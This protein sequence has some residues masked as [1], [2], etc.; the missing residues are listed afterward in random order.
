M[1]KIT[2]FYTSI[3]GVK[4]AIPI[5]A[6]SPLGNFQHLPN[7]IFVEILRNLS[8]K[9]LGILSMTS[10]E[11]REFI[12]STFIFSKNGFKKLNNYQYCNLNTLSDNFTCINSSKLINEIPPSIGYFVKRCTLVLPTEI[13]I[14]HLMQIFLQTLGTPTF[15]M[16]Q[17]Y[18]YRTAREVYQFYGTI[19]N[20]FVSGWREFE[21]YKVYDYLYEICEID[22]KIEIFHSITST[23]TLN[24]NLIELYIRLFFRMIFNLLP[25]SGITEGEKLKWSLTKFTTGTRKQ[26]AK[27][28]ILIFGPIMEIQNGYQGDPKFSHHIAWVEL[29]DQCF[30]NNSLETFGFIIRTLYHSSNHLNI[31]RQY[32]FELFKEII[33]IDFQWLNK[34]VAALLVYSGSS[35]SNAYLRYKFQ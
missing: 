19:I 20:C 13:R 25:E 28:F 7:E 26:T 21:A 31:D 10:S 3:R 2:K 17:K 16:F 11:I 1:T 32:V 34:N 30:I 24:L 8:I 33:T 9:D 6:T 14:Q 12:I 5:V 15:E 23:P 4:M 22:K 27:I 35:F 29:S 18:D